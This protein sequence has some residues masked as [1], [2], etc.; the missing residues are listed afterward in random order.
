MQGGVLSGLRRVTWSDLSTGDIKGQRET[1]TGTFR[2]KE[3]WEAP[4]KKR[5]RANVTVPERQKWQ[6]ASPLQSPLQEHLWVDSNLCRVWAALGEKAT[7]GKALR[8]G[9]SGTLWGSRVCGTQESCRAGEVWL[10]VGRP[11]SSNCEIL[12]QCQEPTKRGKWS[13]GEEAEL[14][15]Q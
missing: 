1:R 12:R 10:E 7:D 9:N 14:G 6:R 13:G 5:V 2:E 11:Q 15:N 8:T 3:G 4:V